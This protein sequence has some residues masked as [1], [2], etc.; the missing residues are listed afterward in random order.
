ML[1]Y[2]RIKFLLSKFLVFFIKISNVSY[3]YKVNI[4]TELEDLLF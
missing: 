2:I 3:M 4:V 1:I